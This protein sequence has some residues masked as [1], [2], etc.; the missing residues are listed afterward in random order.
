MTPEIQAHRHAWEDQCYYG[1]R[2]AVLAGVLGMVGVIASAAAWQLSLPEALVDMVVGAGLWHALTRSVELARDH[3]RKADIPEVLKGQQA[4]Y[5]T[6]LGLIG[7]ILV[8][9]P[10][11]LE[12]PS[13]RPLLE[14]GGFTYV[15]G[16]YA[17]QA[18]ELRQPRA[19]VQIDNDGRVLEVPQGA[20]L[21]DALEGAG[22]RLMV[23]CPRKGQCSSCRVQVTRGARDWPEKYYGKVLT[24]RQRNEGWL[25]SCQVAV[26]GDMAVALYKPLVLRWPDQDAMPSPTARRIRRILPGFDCEACGYATCDAYAQAIATGRAPIT[27]CLPG[28][29]AVKTQLQQVAGELKWSA[30][31]ES[32]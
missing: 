14:V 5:A 13:M 6:L 9:G 12:I 20:S 25:V 16:L 29:Q 18:R 17:W 28:G 11:V 30:T 27:K 8:A 4:R 10:H 32:S 22:Y 1:L 7:L 31:E 15:I 21:L 24:A 23:Q 2:F 26:Q 3:W 19:F